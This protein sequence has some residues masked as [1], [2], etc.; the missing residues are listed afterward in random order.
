V[1]MSKLLHLR[2]MMAQIPV[3]STRELQHRAD[4]KANKAIL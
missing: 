2:R 4:K 1:L 3:T